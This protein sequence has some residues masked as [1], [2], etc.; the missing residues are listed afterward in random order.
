MSQGANQNPSQR[1]RVTQPVVAGYDDPTSVAFNALQGQL[2]L[3]IGTLE[4]YQKQD[5]GQT[6]NWV[7]LSNSSLFNIPGYYPVY[8]GGPYPTIQGAI[9]QAVLD[10][11]GVANPA[12]VQV[13]P[14]V[15]TESDITMQS[16]ISIEGIDKASCR[17][18]GN[19][20]YNVPAGGTGGAVATTL[21]TLQITQPLGKSLLEISGAPADLDIFTAENLVLISPNVGETIPAVI[22]NA[23][24]CITLLTSIN[25]SSQSSGVGFYTI[26]VMACSS[27]SRIENGVW[28]GDTRLALIDTSI[29]VNRVSF[30]S[31]NGPAVEIS[32]TGF[33]TSAYNAIV[34]QNPAPQVGV[35]LLAAGATFACIENIFIVPSHPD[36][37]VVAGPAG[38]NWLFAGA[39]FF[40][41]DL[42]DAA[43]TF[44]VGDTTPTPV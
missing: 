25:T 24:N 5:D 4:I 18:N 28:I 32:A 23:G 1:L 37:R 14:G 30:V 29:S 17:V 16:G 26:H 42:Y 38:S 43:L 10:G 11:Y 21:S 41:S 2:Y 35:N 19:F 22:L 33:M 39:L 9:D 3:R 34:A 15:Y 8:V 13:F 7:L 6:T 31:N 27:A 36:S 40:D 20:I 44:T 12:L